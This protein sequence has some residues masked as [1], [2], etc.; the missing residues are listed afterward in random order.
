[1]AGDERLREYLKRVTVELHDTRVRLHEEQERA[2]E[3]IAIVGMSCRYPGGV[4]S[5]EELWELVVDGRD[6][7]GPFPADRGWDLE[8]LVDRGRS[9]DAVRESG[10]LYDAGEFDAAFFGISPR[11]ALAMDPQQ[12]QVLE[13]VLGGARG[14]RDR[15]DSLR[16]SR[17][18]VFAR[19]D[20]P[21]LRPRGCARCRPTWRASW[22]PAT[23]AS[24]VSGTGRLRA[25]PR[26]PRG[27]GRHRLL[28]LA[29]GA[30]PRVRGAA[31]RRVHAG[32]RRRCDGDGHAERVRR[33]RPPGRARAGRPLQVLRATRPTAPAGARASACCVL[34]RLSDARRHGHEVLAL[35]RGSAVNQDGAS[36]GLTAPNGPSQQR[37]IRQ[38]L[39]E[40]AARGGRGRRGRGA[41]NRH[42]AR[43]PDRGAGAAR[44]LRPG[45]FRGRP[46]VA[47]V[48][49]VEH[50]PHPGRGGRGGRD[51]DGAWR[52]ATACCRGRCTS[53]SP[54]GR[55]IGRAGAISLLDGGGAVAAAASARAAR[56]CR[57]SG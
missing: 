15:P 44:D 13:V 7:I 27:D 6:A 47:G 43:R 1:M 40:R 28:L 34:E 4:R 51:Q 25:R 12:R 2:H 24:V 33:V 52:C 36:N 3:P 42:D 56:A 18:A 32:A 29:G 46:A 14:R 41:R 17:T 37:V 39:A 10:F 48:D 16:G 54:R 49:Q 8:R 11:E 30:A 21:R 31:R 26:G 9:R 38:A 22:G 19:P 45:S 50:R 53:T 55:S 20:V 5:P 23:P 35:V 57:R